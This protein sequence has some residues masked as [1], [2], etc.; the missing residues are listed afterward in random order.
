MPV[1]L[2]VAF[3][4]VICCFHHDRA[5]SKPLPCGVEDVGYNNLA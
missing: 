2:H 4:T 3:R 1:C 5:C